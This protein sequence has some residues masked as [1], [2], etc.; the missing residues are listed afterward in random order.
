MGCCNKKRIKKIEN[1]GYSESNMHFDQKTKAGNNPNNTDEFN[2]RRNSSKIAEEEF[3]EDKN[4][5]KIGLDNI[6]AIYYKNATLQY[7]SNKKDI[8]NYFLKKYKYKKN[9]ENKKLSNEFY[10]VI[11]NLWDKKRNN[12]SYSPNEFKKTIS[13]MNSLFQGVQAND[14]K[15]LINFLLE[16]LHTELNIISEKINNNENNANAMNIQTDKNKLY[17]LFLNNYKKN[18]NSII[19]DS[20][21]GSIQ[22]QSICQ[23]CRIVKYNY[24]IVYFFEFPLEQINIYFGKTPSNI[25]YEL[26]Q[27]EINL[28]ECFNFYQKGEIMTKDNAMYCDLCNIT[29]DSFY[30]T[31]IYKP[32]KYLI[33]ILNRG[34]G[35]IYKCNVKFHE[36]LDIKSFVENKNCNTLYDLYAVICHFGPSSMGGHFIAYA[37]NALNDKWYGYND[38]S[39]TLCKEKNYLTGVPYIHFYQEIDV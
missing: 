10:I 18:Y 11:K 22:T 28:N 37:R 1:F 29:C 7:L 30:I 17:E 26:V 19:S 25:N 5:I 39:V 4:S 35:N 21:Y 12:K 13:E 9:D 23:N 36:I 34:K 14:S 16:Q 2:K 31:K 20:F 32:P 6:D 15:D 3:I 8:N 27:P 38:S 33:L 24:E